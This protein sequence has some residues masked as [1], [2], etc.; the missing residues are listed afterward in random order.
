MSARLS[1]AGSLLAA[2]FATTLVAQTDPFTINPPLTSQGVFSCADLTMSSGIVDSSGLASTTPTN[3]AVLRSNGNVKISGGTVNGDAIAGPGKLVQLSGSGTV[4]G[5]ASSAGAT[6][7]CTPIDLAALASTLQTSNDNASIPLTA[8]NKNPLTGSTHTDF[9]LGGGDSVTLHAGTYYFT[10]ISLSGGSIVHLDGVVRI[11]CTGRVDITGGSFFNSDHS[12]YSLR[13][14][15]SGTP[16]NLSS[17]TL[18]AIVYAPAAAATVSAGTLKGSLF[19]NVVTLSGSTHITQALDD[20]APH[21]T[22]ISPADGSVATAAS[23]AVTGNATDDQTAVNLTV[24]G[25]PVAVAADGSFQTTVNIAGLS[26]VTITATASDAA[27]NSADT[28]VTLT[29]ARPTISGIVPVKG[30]TAGGTTVTITGTNFTT[31]ADTTVRIGGAPAAQV[32]V[33]S[34]TSLNA[35]TPVGTAGAADVVISTFGGSA[36]LP[37]GFA[38]L[39]PPT[40]TSF[41][42]TSARVGDTVT[43]TGINFDSDPAGNRVTIGST[44]A[45]VTS[46]TATM[47][48][49]IVPQGA[50]SAPISVTTA[51]GTAT[52]TTSFVV[53]VYASVAISPN[54]VTLDPGQTFQLSLIATLVGGGTVDVTSPATWSSGTPAVATVAAGLVSAIATGSATITATF[55]GFQAT[56]SVAVH[57]SEPVPPDPS[58]VAT[59]IDPTVVGVFV[60]E[61]KFLYTGASP[62]QTGVVGGAIDDNRAA[63]VRGTVRTQTGLPLPAVTVSIAGHPEFGQTLS[64]ADGVFDLV[65]NGGGT[66]ALQFTK[67][68]FISAQR[69]VS[70]VWGQRTVIDDVAL[71]G[72]DPQVTA[73]TLSA[74]NEQVARGSIMN[75]A[76]GSRR[77][78]LLV[79]P[80]TTAALK[81][82][83]GTTQSAAALHVRATEFTVGSSGPKAM[84]AELPPT[85]GYTYCVELSADEAI[86]AGAT[87]VQFSKAL[88][89]YVENFLGFAAGTIVPVG[90][91]DRQRVAWVPSDNGIVLKVVSVTN[92][93]ANLDLN[94][95]GVA[96][97]PTSLGI[98]TAERQTLASLYAPGQSLWRVPVTHFTPFDE[99]WP[100][101]PLE[102][103]PGDAVPPSQ[104]QPLWIPAP[105]SDDSSGCT[106]G[107]STVNC[108]TATL[109]ESIPIVGTP[110][111]LEYDSARVAP[112]QNSMTITL[113]GA[114][115]PA[116]LKRIDLAITVAGT[117]RTLNFAPQMN[118]KYDFTWDGLDVFGR[119]APGAREAGVLLSY[120]YDSVYA[121]PVPTGKAW[122]DYTLQSTGVKGRTEITMSQA[123]TIRL[124]HFDVTTAGFG[125]WTFS[126]QRFYDGRGGAIYDGGGGQRNGDPNQ[127]GQLAVTTY[128]GNM[129]FRYSGDGGPATQAG[130]NVP[131]YLAAGPD[132]A[133]YLCDTNVFNGCTRIR[134]V[135]PNTHIINTVAGNGTNGFTPDGSFALGNPIAARSLSVGPDNTLY[136]LDGN[137]VRRIVDGLLITIAGNGSPTNGVLPPEGAV[138]TQV[139]MTPIALAVGRDGTVYISQNPGVSRITSDGRIST[140]LVFR[141]MQ[142]LAVGPGGELY[143]ADSFAVFRIIAGT[144]KV[145]GGVP[146]GGPNLPPLVDGQPATSGTMSRPSSLD[147]APDGTVVVSEVGGSI[148]RIRAIGTNG[149]ATTIMGTGKFPDYFKPPASGLLGRSS[150]VGPWGVT[151][152][153][154]GSVYI[155]D[156]QLGLIRRAAGVFPALSRTA[157][158]VPSPDGSMAYVFDNG[159]HVSTA[160][161]MTGTTLLRL[162]YDANGFVATLTDLDGN[163][164]TIERQPDGTPTAIV[165]PG[166]QRTTLEVTDGH[167]MKVTNP[168]GQSV[169][170]LYDAAGLLSDFHDA[171][172]GL[173]HFTYDPR[174][175]VT[176]D[177]AP[178]GSFFTLTRNGTG[179]N[180]TVTRTTA[181]GHVYN[182]KVN[183]AADTTVS[184]EQDAPDGKALTLTFNA[185]TTKTQS[186]DG[187]VLT[188]TNGPDPRYGMGASFMSTGTLAAGGKQATVTSSRTVTPDPNNPLA[189]ASL[190]QLFSLNGRQWSTSYDGATHRVTTRTPA[191]RTTVSTLD[192]AGRV[193]SFS[194][195]GIAAVNLTYGSF[196]LLASATQG[197]RATSYG[198]DTKHR[199]SSITDPMQHTVS[200]MYD[201]AD[202]VTKQTFS[203]GSS[204][205]FI[206]DENGNITSV[207][208][209][210]R[211]QHLFAFTPADLQSTY[212]APLSPSTRYTYNRDRQLTLISRPDGTSI[213]PGYDSFGRLASLGI[214]RGTYSYGYDATTGQLRTITAP[215]GSSLAYG[216]AGPLLMSV[217][218]SGPVSWT[219][220]RTYDNDFHVATEAVAGSSVSFSYDPDGLMLTAGALTLQHDVQN[221]FLTGT[222]LGAIADT[223]GYNEFGEPLSYSA[224]ASA[225]LFSEQVT[226]DDVGRISQKVENVAGISHTYDYFY[227]D[228]G[229]LSDVVRD[230][231]TTTSYRYDANGNR[232]LLSINGSP[233]AVAT[234]DDEDRLTAY[235][236]ATYTYTASG[237][238]SS[239]A[240][241][242]GTTGYVYDELGN[243]TRV[244]LPG[245]PTIDYLIDGQ[246]RRVGKRIDGALV[247]AFAYADQ[248]RIIAE[249]DGAGNL[250]SRFIYGSRQNVPDYMIKGGTT[251]R[252]IAD[253]L[254]SPRLVVNAATGAVI[255]ELDYDEFG[256]V[257]VDTN[258]GFQPFGF[259]GG[260]YDPSTRLLRFGARDYDP[261]TGRWTAK[262][263]LGFTA[264]GTNFYAY[265]L[266]DPVNRVDVDGLRV[267]P[268]NFVGPLQPGDVRAFQA[269]L[270][271]PDLK[272]LVYDLQVAPHYYGESH[273]CVALTKH[274]TGAPCAESCWTKG[275]KVLGN[276]IPMGT[277]VAAGWKENGRYPAGDD[278]DPRNSGIYVQTF[279][280]NSIE[281][282]EQWPGHLPQARRIYP[283]G[284]HGPSNDSTAYNVIKARCSCGN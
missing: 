145:I 283:G 169:S 176:R 32:V 99:N 264:G 211:P 97:D 175:L 271:S 44:L 123:F 89:F 105:S 21:V 178:D 229:H 55:N 115:I 40:I 220:S 243:L 11:L 170:M 13:L 143:G 79:P 96:D 80:G 279:P 163:V 113:S 185:A 66:I 82:A 172:Q 263:A 119:R 41:S 187:S 27:G 222:T 253:H 28:S 181:E 232:R 228:A 269:D 191:G 49:I 199:L 137:R 54:S 9:T 87:E 112:T 142:A 207:T 240:D 109:S 244:T 122:N 214:A 213:V 116:S 164:T 120:V 249:L 74:A 174:G 50:S 14:W 1:L 167:L 84:P 248:L 102:I 62:I 259:A 273:Q 200:F 165:A 210:S 46:A 19:A 221:G 138:A 218:Y 136:F 196:G 135:D 237:D 226:R 274:F 127:T 239:R 242:S 146:F 61:V 111:F 282:I 144:M 155:V 98:D 7:N 208:P 197:A 173:H 156:Q 153:P 91:Y 140:A 114:T 148:P 75:D 125:T 110:F 194:R 95:D 33:T 65:C 108:Y 93:L 24:N 71:I 15:V 70:T 177:D 150:P 26:P 272:P 203:D 241:V 154:D 277:A 86:A 36:T 39:A 168:A 235:G 256:N 34:S 88:P 161:T 252:I 250:V 190:T 245:G 30:P 106:N 29:V 128:A 104:P 184:R 139:P 206:R 20:V 276:D 270:S 205:S 280:D 43:I 4:T 76:D 223:F 262:E 284:T 3:R 2:L 18:G 234:S 57:S 81:L 266:G 251:Y 59:K 38:Y 23:V 281:L 83:D 192:S 6:T 258:P 131:N 255:Q 224:S 209:P 68:N 58:T 78:T 77:A 201:D 179:E 25:Q 151:V 94:G 257:F 133:V 219:V 260:L 22:I 130:I 107:A 159:R 118:L 16:F 152:G 103:T 100:R 51:G 217:T 132:G 247:Q 230:G 56:A 195:P 149:I 227:D 215:G 126:P 53:V 63:T 238:L 52:S 183:T 8:Q 278:P 47:L 141:T 158:V 166:G 90:Y 117:K 147:V 121:R 67:S 182:Y 5:T 265:A 60:D 254:G 204:V 267:Y 162:G 193:S 64:R 268:A 198:Y 160:E 261:Q 37:G 236:D 10:K 225:L 92:G 101:V 188:T 202:R 134:R 216:L 189:L 72:Y 157:T 212:T 31:S 246:N 124:G 45:T 186:T 85:T 275:P 129:S 42:P 73:I 233:I 48:V 17:S 231:A 171:R 12:P 180:Y 35:R 69:S